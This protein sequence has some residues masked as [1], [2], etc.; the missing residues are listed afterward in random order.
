VHAFFVVL[1]KAAPE[2]VGAGRKVELRDPVLLG[3]GFGNLE[4]GFF[5]AG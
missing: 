5:A 1:G 3:R 2:P 4:D